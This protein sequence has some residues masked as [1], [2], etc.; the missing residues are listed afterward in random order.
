MSLHEDIFHNCLDSDDIRG[1][2]KEGAIAL[3]LV[4]Y[5]VLI[6]MVSQPGMTAKPA[7]V[8]YHG[9]TAKIPHVQISFVGIGN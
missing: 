2:W 1:G 7:H 5:L 6:L 4:I 3:E 8:L 9:E